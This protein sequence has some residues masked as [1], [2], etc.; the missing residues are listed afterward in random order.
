[1]GKKPDPSQTGDVDLET[2]R[3]QALDLLE[4]QKTMV[5][6]VSTAN[7]PWAAPVF[8][9]YKS[10]G[11][12]FFSSP[13]SKHIQALQNSLLAAGAIYA[14]S[15]R[16]QDIHGLQMVGKVEEVQGKLER[17]NIT[18]YYLVKFPMARDLLVSGKDRI[19]DLRPKVGLYVFSPSEIYCTNNSLG[20]GRR[21]QIQL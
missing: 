12:Y 8:Y 16:W 20:F 15:Q 2:Y 3:N 4:R 18:T 13:R 11:I 9:L 10:P 17:L 14:D 19:R 5:L 21:V 7:R 1:M 6:A